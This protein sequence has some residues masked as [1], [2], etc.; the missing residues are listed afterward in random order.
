MTKP[1]RYKRYSV[2]FKREAL[3]KAANRNSIFLL[4]RYLFCPA[5]LAWPDRR[6]SH[7]R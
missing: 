4:F 2:E 6:F 5:P 7:G 1:K 3:R